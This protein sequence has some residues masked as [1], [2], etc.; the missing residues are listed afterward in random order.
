MTIKLYHVPVFDCLPSYLFKLKMWLQKINANSLIRIRKNVSQLLIKP[1]NN[2]N[3]NLSKFRAKAAK[4]NAAKIAE[5]PEAEVHVNAGVNLYAN[6]DADKSSSSSSSSSSSDNS[7]AKDDKSSVHQVVRRC[8]CHF[9]FHWWF[10]LCE[11]VV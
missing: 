11:I 6:M 7:L 1:L 8:C 9:V 2:L 5:E 3:S 4:V 10:M